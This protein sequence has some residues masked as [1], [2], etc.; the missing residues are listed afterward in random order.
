[1]AAS[2]YLT[3][4]TSTVYSHNQRGAGAVADEGDSAAVYFVGRNERICDAGL[5]GRAAECDT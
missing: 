3:S 2:S 5:Y 4:V 1:M